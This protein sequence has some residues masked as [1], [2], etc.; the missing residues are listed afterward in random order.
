MTYYF[1]TRYSYLWPPPP[2][3]PTPHF[4]P[5]ATTVITFNFFFLITS[6]TGKKMEAQKGPEIHPWLY[7]NQGPDPGLEPWWSASRLP[8]ST[9]EMHCLH[10]TSSLS[11]GW[12]AFP[13]DPQPA[14]RSRYTQDSPVLEPLDVSR[15][16]A[17]FSDLNL[18]P[19][20]SCRAMW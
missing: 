8:L 9:P 20:S 12:V 7:S 14:H 16:A 6:F 18:N 1:T 13:E 17:S 11:L 5:L 4:L 15:E 10:V 3:P 19:G 2:I